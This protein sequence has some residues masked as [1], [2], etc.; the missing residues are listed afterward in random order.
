MCKITKY[1][2]ANGKFR[3][4]VLIQGRCPKSSLLIKKYQLIYL[5][6]QSLIL[7]VYDISCHMKKVGINLPINEY[8]LSSF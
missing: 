8:F 4:H 6:V 1:I 5:Q 3:R 7:N 2:L